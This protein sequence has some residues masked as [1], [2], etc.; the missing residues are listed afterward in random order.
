[1]VATNS[2]VDL[3]DVS[4]GGLTR[5][6]LTD[7]TGPYTAVHWGPA[8][9]SILVGQAEA[10]S[11][12]NAD[13]II[14]DGHAMLAGLY[15]YEWSETGSNKPIRML[16]SGLGL[17]RQPAYS[18]DGSRIIFSSN[19]SG[20][21][22]LWTIDRRT[23]LLR[24]P[25]NDWDPAYTPSGE[26]I[27]WSSDRS[28]N[29][30]IWMAAADGSGARQVTH[31]GVDAEN[32][33]M[34][35][36]GEWIVHASANDL[37]LGVWKLRPDGSDATLLAPGAYL[38]PEVSPNGEYVLFLHQSGMNNVI[39]VAEIDTG[40]RIPFRIEISPRALHRNIT[41]GRARWTPDGRAIVYVG[42]D[43]EGRTGVFVQDFI[44]GSDTSE[45]R[46]KLAGFST[47]FATESL[48]IPPDGK[49]IVIS[50]VSDRR[51]LRLAE[52]VSLQAWE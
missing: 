9:R 7:W 13:Q 16:T 30:E 6:A 3:I 33:T 12:L 32:P 52:F 40:E 27:L 26:Q 18:P 31:D 37:R 14:I 49:S 24:H 1:M 4:T 11:V 45:S 47:D 10:I 25:A 35:A 20:N 19:R 17:D 41:C 50:A 29:M 39:Q 15:E 8:G 48:G 51:S 23:G 34:T 43:D 2:F 22:D 38:I 21:V 42:E 5:L 46:K 44:P 36:D 28:G